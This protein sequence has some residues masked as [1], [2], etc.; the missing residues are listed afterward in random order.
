MLYTNK[1]WNL[2]TFD[3]TTGS[4][5]TV[6]GLRLQPPREA[7]PLVHTI[8]L[9]SSFFTTIRPFGAHSLTHGAEPF[10]RSRQLCSY[11]IQSITSHPI[12]LTSIL[13]LSTHLRLGLSSGLCNS[14]NSDTDSVVKQITNKLTR[15]CTP[16]SRSR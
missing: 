11:S 2:R 4:G 14:I 13:I 9:Y 16:I 15:A 7:G 1:D 8:I 3:Y 5:Q 6:T 12:S 10:L